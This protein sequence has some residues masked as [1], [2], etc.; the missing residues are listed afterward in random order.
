MSRKKSQEVK[1]PVPDA[2]TQQIKASVSVV[3]AGV[4]AVAPLEFADEQAKIAWEVKQAITSVLMRVPRET[5]G[6][7]VLSFSPEHAVAGEYA[8]IFAGTFVSM[9]EVGV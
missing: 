2:A 9:P 5:F 8:I 3:R 7:Q 6:T 1:I 4:N